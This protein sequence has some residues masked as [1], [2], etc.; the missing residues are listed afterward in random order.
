MR[1]EPHS[2]APAVQRGSERHELT[3][4]DL[5]SQPAQADPISHFCPWAVEPELGY[6]RRLHKAATAAQARAQREENS[7]ARELFWL[8]AQVASRWNFRRVDDPATLERILR[9]LSQM[10]MAADNIRQEEGPHAW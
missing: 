7:T 6:R 1:Q 10:F 3:Q 9:A 8:A 2:G 5:K 4:G